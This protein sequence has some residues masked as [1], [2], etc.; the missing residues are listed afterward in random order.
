MTLTPQLAQQ[1]LAEQICR[2]VAELPDRNSPEDWPEA[3]LVTHDELRAIVLSA[4]REALASG[5][6]DEAMDAARYRECLEWVRGHISR[7]DP[8]GL[9]NHIAQ[10]IDAALAAPA[11][12]GEVGNG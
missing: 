6:G 2:E 7:Y 11:G 1:C 8:P 3:M 12:G 10:R 9:P 4:L 5:E